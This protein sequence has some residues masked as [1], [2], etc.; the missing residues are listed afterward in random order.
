MDVT[1]GALRAIAPT[2]DEIAR[3]CVY[4]PADRENLGADLR[5]HRRAY[6]A[7]GTF[8][9]SRPGAARQVAA[10]CARPNRS[11][12][13]SELDRLSIMR[14]EEVWAQR[15]VSVALGADVHEHDDNSANSMYDLRIGSVETPTVALEVVGAVDR[16]WTETWNVGPGRSGK[17]WDVSGN[18]LL[19]I[20]PGTHIKTLKR[21][22]PPLLRTLEAMGVRDFDDERLQSRRALGDD[23]AD[24]LETLGVESLH[25]FEPNGEGTI[26]MTM[27]GQGGM[28]HESGHLV[29][30]WVVEFLTHADQADVLHKLTL[31]SAALRREVF[32]PVT[33]M[34]APWSVTSYLTGTLDQLPVAC[35]LL[36]AAVD[37]VWLAPT[38]SF[39]DAMG[40]RW[41]GSDWSK[42][43]IRGEG[44][45]SP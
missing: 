8:Y 3:L 34:G 14:P 30:D 7:V 29:S 26:H 35:P 45:D 21:E 31:A 24:A 18:W 1:P 44:I 20:Q 41:D 33:L 19:T 25:C 43:R 42:F 27:P 17:R 36:P 12:T 32:I 15:I 37:G 2:G 38:M 10:E 40:V 22:L 4:G 16:E 6:S 28:V 23:V 5:S 11:P 39:H 13:P 9:L